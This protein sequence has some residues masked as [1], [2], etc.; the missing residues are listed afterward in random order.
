[1][2]HINQLTN[3]KLNKT[4]N[5]M[6]SYMIFLPMSLMVSLVNLKKE[7]WMNRKESKLIPSKSYYDKGL[8]YSLLIDINFIFSFSNY[9]AE[10]RQPT[11]V[12]GL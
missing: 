1:M 10:V 6:A 12:I 5:S 3:R 7:K 4:K 9:G 2:N 11:A 8:D